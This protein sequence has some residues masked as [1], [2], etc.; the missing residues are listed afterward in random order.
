MTTNH[1]ANN[2]GAGSTAHG[3]DFTNFIHEQMEE[4]ITF[5]GFAVTYDR[6]FNLG[7]FER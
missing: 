6:K 4:P 7:N 2:N 1:E 5:K 3:D